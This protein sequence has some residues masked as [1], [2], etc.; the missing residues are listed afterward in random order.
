MFRQAEDLVDDMVDHLRAVVRVSMSDDVLSDIVTILIGDQLRGAQMDL[1]HQLLL[2]SLGSLFKHTLDNATTKVVSCQCMYL[3]TEGVHH[4]WKTLAWHHRDDL[5]NNMI[6]I[7]VL[8]NSQDVWLE[9][10][11]DLFLLF[12]QNMFQC[13]KDPGQ[14][15][16]SIANEGLQLGTYLL[17]DAACVHLS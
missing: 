15:E 1:R 17:D 2:L 16:F 11:D 13:L 4:E 8:D 10:R 7:L 5:L 12:N 14:F 9:F 6:A 3:T